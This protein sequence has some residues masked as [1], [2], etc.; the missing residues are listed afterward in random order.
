ML[1]KD[2][3]ILFR[4]DLLKLQEEISAYKKE[5]VI[6]TIDGAIS[7]S[8]GNL[9]LHLVGNLNTY[10]GAV[11]GQ[12]EYIRNRELEFS[13]KDL[14]RVELLQLIAATI[15]VVEQALDRLSAADLEKEYPMLVFDR[16][17]TTGYFL[18]HL[19]VHLGYHLG[20]INYHRRLL[21]R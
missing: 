15:P 3:K 12:T 19:S 14:S 18:V 10:L 13:R 20:Q 4:R 11:I 2:L 16:P 17:T 21:D 1:L 8:A 9:A 5:A 6:W 7:N